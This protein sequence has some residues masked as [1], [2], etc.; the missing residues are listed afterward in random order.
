M[1]TDPIADMLSCIRNAVLVK[2]R[3][4]DIPASNIKEKI[5]TILKREGYIRNFKRLNQK[6]Q[7]V[8]RVF[9]LY[10][11]DGEPYIL[12]LK[13]ISRPGRRVYLPQKNVKK[14]YNGYGIAIITTSKGIL[15][16][17]E[18]RELG[19]GGEIVCHIW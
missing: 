8:L 9:L 18:V 5:L 6:P 14:V 19:I 7:D 13:R 3:I 11:K 1:V 16:D 12:G 2:K 4:V 15:T 17:K 10:A